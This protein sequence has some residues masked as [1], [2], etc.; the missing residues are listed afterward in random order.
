MLYCSTRVH[1]QFVEHVD[2]FVKVLFSLL[3]FLP[4]VL[5]CASGSLCELL[6]KIL[7]ALLEHYFPI[8]AVT[9]SSIERACA[10]KSRLVDIY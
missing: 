7:Y 2:R 6:S 8:W 4:V 1:L 10:G 9:W 5:Y 3:H